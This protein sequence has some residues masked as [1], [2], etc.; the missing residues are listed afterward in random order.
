MKMQVFE[1]P[2]LLPFQT[3]AS[4]HLL[5][6]LFYTGAFSLLNLHMM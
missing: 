3:P 2:L 6:W 5:S 1:M 4:H